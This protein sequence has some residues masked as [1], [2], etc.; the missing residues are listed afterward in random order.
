MEYHTKLSIAGL[1]EEAQEPQT[2]NLLLAGLDGEGDRGYLQKHWSYLTVWDSHVCGFLK[3]RR[4][5]VFLT[6]GAHISQ[7]V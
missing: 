1:L 7:L 6:S 3:N 5:T 2:L 4:Q